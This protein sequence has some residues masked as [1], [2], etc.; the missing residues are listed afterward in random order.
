M[1]IIYL[2]HPISGDVEGNIKKILKIVRD[3]NLTEPDVFPF[4]HYL[5]DCQA[6][7]DTVPKE[8]ARGIKNDIAIFQKKGFLDEVRLYGNRISYGMKCEI[9]LARA[10]NI[11]II[12]MTE[13]TKLDLGSL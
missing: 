1:R 12:A 8:R 4:A 11:P 7:D 9:E 5:V 6:L 13:E 2:A 10:N 3:I